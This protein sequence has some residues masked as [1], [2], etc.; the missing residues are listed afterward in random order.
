MP[1][2]EIGLGRLG[3]EELL[4]EM[5][6]LWLVSWCSE[7][8]RFYWVFFTVFSFAPQE[9]SPLASRSVQKQL[10]LLGEKKTLSA[11][12]FNGSN[13]HCGWEVRVMV[14]HV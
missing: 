7:S 11:I 9:C 2:Q 13:R 8:Q 3:T 10:E 14:R 6:H 1:S 12:D 4:E 5:L